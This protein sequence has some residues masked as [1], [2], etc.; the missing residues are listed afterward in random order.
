MKNQSELLDFF[1]QIQKIIAKHGFEKFLSEIKKIQ[2]DLE[3]IIEQK[4]IDYILLI[5]AK[6]YKIE[7]N[8]ILNSKKRGIIAESR[9]MAFALLKEHLPFTDEEIG[10]CFGGRSRQYVNKELN[11]N[12]DLIG[13]QEYISSTALN[14]ITDYNKYHV[15]MESL[16]QD[17]PSK[18]TF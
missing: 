5:T 2:I 8:D 4:I 12:K 3:N 17:V 10:D 13:T 6:H 16:F 14:A 15:I 18:I 11:Y 1:K 7:V 9:R